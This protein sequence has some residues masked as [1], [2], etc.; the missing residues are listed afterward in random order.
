M[1]KSL[2]LRKNK[3]QPVDKSC[4]SII[5]QRFETLFAEH[6]KA[7]RDLIDFLSYDKAKISRIVNGQEIPKLQDRVRIAQFFRIDSCVIWENPDCKIRG[8]K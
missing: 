4:W 1:N 2:D 3:H 6:K 8:R 7:R 5:R